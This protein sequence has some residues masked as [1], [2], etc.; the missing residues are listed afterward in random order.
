MSTK[1]STK[2]VL[3]PYHTNLRPCAFMEYWLLDSPHLRS[4]QLR[5]SLKN[6]QLAR[7]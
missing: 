7:K 3:R 5:R 6:Q 4:Y 2:L 1:K